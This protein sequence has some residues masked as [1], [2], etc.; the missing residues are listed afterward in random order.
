MSHWVL[1]IEAYDRR[2]LRKLALRR[3]PGL[4]LFMRGVTRLGDPAVVVSLAGLL[5]LVGPGAAGRQALLALVLSHL[6]SQ[7]LKR[8]IS[9]PR[10]ALP[11]GL[12]S[13]IQPPDR[14]SFPSGHA[15]ASMALGLPMALALP[16][17]T[18]LA[19]LLL[20]L[21]VGVSRCYLGV[22]YPGD[23]LAGW[24]LGLLSVGLVIL[25]RG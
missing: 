22:H 1:R 15:S 13:L 7:L 25:G 20:A 11:V 9:R 2:L 10:P 16:Q 18:A 19:L 24:C 5:L 21:S 8:T 23:V 14:F 17:G 3:R 6:L 4:T 12:A